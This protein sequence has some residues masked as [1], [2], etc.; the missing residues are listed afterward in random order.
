MTGSGRR[1]AWLLGVV[2]L[3]AACT[4][5]PGQPAGPAAPSSLAV[6]APPAGGA[7]IA[8][9]WRPVD[10]RS[11]ESTM[12]VVAITLTGHM[13]PSPAEL[14]DAN[15]ALRAWPPLHDAYA[16]TTLRWW[17][18]AEG[19]GLILYTGLEVATQEPAT[20]TKIVVLRALVDQDRAAYAC[21]TGVKAADVLAVAEELRTALG[22]AR[23]DGQPFVWQSV[24]GRVD[25]RLSISGLT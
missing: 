22:A 13:Q 6:Q 7:L 10:T 4:S 21:L 16:A 19:Q 1:L 15:A 23:P 18:H 17:T 25:A 3:A 20:D 5:S 2:A 14:A 11:I 8:A 12:T 24:Y 9:G